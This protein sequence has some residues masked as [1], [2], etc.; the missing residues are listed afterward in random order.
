MNV[1]AHILKDISE[2][3]TVPAATLGW[4]DF[5]SHPDWRENLV[6]TTSLLWHPERER[7]VVGMTS[8]QTDLMYEFD[9]A[10]SEFHCLDF[11]AVSEPFEI[12]IH[13][14]LALD[15]EGRVYGA[16]ACLHREDQRHEGPGGRIFRYDFDA[17][18]YEFLGIPVPHD[19]IQ[20]I[21]LD[22]E[23]GVIYG[24]TYPVFNFFAYDYNRRETIYGHYVGSI[25]HLMALDE[26]GGCWSTWSPRT[27]NLYRYDPE[28]NTIEFYH[29]GLPG[30]GAG[31][32]L[33]Y[34]GAGPVDM[35]LNGDDGYIY[36]GVANGD[37]VCLDPRTAETTYVGR[38]SPE[39]RLP[40]LEVGPDGRLW[41]IC[42]FLG[43]CRLFAYDREK[44]TF[45][46]YGHIADTE[47]GEPIYIAHDMAFAPD[48]T[49]FVGE[50]DTTER[51]SYLWELRG[52][53]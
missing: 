10:T 7:L 5:T 39:T 40:A 53:F 6:A 30:Q 23:R 1:K 8:F 12:K 18:T 33:M 28:K 22:E 2:P 36:I 13:R 4:R 41:G 21:T 27:H 14:S 19:Y 24:L 51:A 35:M 45:Q 38:P 16:T 20:T 44:R 46:D 37:L 43:R 9:P 49:L 50:T 29:H 34:P 47:T 32:G 52:L 48:G 15:S 11:M 42:G 3:I 26:D 17:G 31:A 25:S